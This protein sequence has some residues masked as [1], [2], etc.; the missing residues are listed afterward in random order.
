[1]APCDGGVRNGTAV[2]W[3]EKR[4]C[5]SDFIGVELLP[6]QPH[7]YMKPCC[8]HIYVTLF[9]ATL[10][11]LLAEFPAGG[12]VHVYVGSSTLLGRTRART[13][14]ILSPLP[15]ARSGCAA[16]GDDPQP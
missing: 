12:G 15:H 4:S 10:V 5:F 1:M 8:L 2:A 3:D 7:S 11:A 13:L 6:D 14:A 16:C 9:H